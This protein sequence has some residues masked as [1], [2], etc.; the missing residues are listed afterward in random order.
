MPKRDLK[1]RYLG[2]AK[3]LQKASGKAEKSLGGVD[4][5]SRKT[6]KGLGL[7]K[8]GVGKLGLALGGAALIGGAAKA[9][10]RAEEMSSAYAATEAIILATGGAAGL[11][12]GQI[13]GMA[14]EMS[15]ATGV[16]KAL[17]IE[18]QN[19]LLT[20]KNIKDE[21]GEG[22]DVFSRTQEVMLDLAAVMKTD[23]K[24]SALQLGKALNDPIKGVSQLQRI[25]VTFSDVQKEQIRNF[26]EAGDV[27]SAQGIILTELEGQVGGVAEATADSTAKISNAWK[28]VQEQIGNALLP[29]IDAIV[30]SMQAAARSAPSVARNI[31]LAFS[32][33]GREIDKASDALRTVTFGLIDLEDKWTD[34]QEALFQVDRRMIKYTENLGL[35]REESELFV[36]VL[37]DLN[38]KGDAYVGTVQSLIEATGIS[39]EEFKKAALF[40]LGNAEAL[41]LTEEQADN[42]KRELKKLEAGTSDMS[43][44]ALINAEALGEMAESEEEVKDRGK[45][46]LTAVN[47]LKTAMKELTDPVFAAKRANEK[48]EEVLERVQE[49]LILTDDEAVELTEAWIAQ[50]TAADKVNAINIDAALKAEREALGLLD[51]SIEVT[52]AGYK[53]LNSDSA[54]EMDRF[55]RRA[56]TVASTPIDIKITASLPTRAAF[57]AAVRGAITRAKRRGIDG[58]N[59]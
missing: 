7:L 28:E 32:G 54:F 45:E 52:K 3:S 20:F 46:A 9:I 10:A 17:I 16:D 58:I 22:N 4:Q 27:A 26:Q 40:A 19:L 25:G 2:D 48:L 21:A 11:T 34:Q 39:G 51:D 33:A 30:P 6:G 31:G 8:S 57:D 55:I 59:F 1:F 35:G 23:A 24:S 36:G 29:A 5:K 47:D 14:V 42:L 44:V 50:Q 18:G 13:K 37:R 56:Q 12:G 49:D 41:G 53:S 43:G 38:K 15:L